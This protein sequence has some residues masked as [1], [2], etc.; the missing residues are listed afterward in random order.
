MTRGIWAGVVGRELRGVLILAFVVGALGWIQASEASAAGCINESLRAGPSEFLPDCRGYELVTPPDTNGRL[1]DG[2]STFGFEK[3]PGF[4]PTELG[5]PVRDSLLYVAYNSPLASPGESTGIFD[6][7]EAERS[8]AGW[9]TA[10]RRNPSGAQA[11]TPEPGGASPDHLYA[12]SHVR[13]IEGGARPAGSLAAEGNGEYLSNPDGSFELVGVGGE[14]TE[15]LAQGRFISANGEH[16]IFTTGRAFTQSVDCW[17]I[18]VKCP[19]HPLESNAPPAGTGAVYDRS[20]DGPTHV[21]SL[22]PGDARPETGEEAFYQGVSKDGSSVVFKINEVLYV[23]ADNGLAEER[24]EEVATGSTTFAG[25]SADGRYVFYV[26]AGDIHRFD[27]T[28][29]VDAQVNST[30]DGK[31]VNVSADGSH[32]YFIS[33]EEIEGQGAAGKPNLFVWSGG[34]PK[35]V[36][37]VAASDLVRTSGTVEGMP[38]LTNWTS[39]VVS[40]ETQSQPGPGAD[41]SRTTPDGSVIVFESRARLTSYDNGGHTEIYRYQEGDP[42]PTCISC[43]PAVEPAEGDARLQELFMMLPPVVIHNLSD[44]GGH[45]FFETPE[46]LAGRDTDGV[47]DV[48]EWKQE[49]GGSSVNLISSGKSLEYKPLLAR[50]QYLPSPNILFS[51]TPDGS[52]VFFLSQD[53]LVPGAGEEGAPAVYDARVG[54]GFP[55]AP[56]PTLCLEEECHSG[57]GSAPA[58]QGQQSEALHGS[59]NVKPGRHRHCRRAHHKKGQHGRSVKKCGKRRF[60]RVRASTAA[61]SAQPETTTAQSLQASSG[62]GPEPAAGTSEPVAHSSSFLTSSG[63]EF[64]EF[65]I[66]AVSAEGSTTAAG[67]HPDFTTVLALNSHVNVKNHQVQ[68]DAR[69]EEVSVSLPPGLLG[70]PNAIPRCSVGGLIAFGNC[71]VGS[72]VGLARL[73]ISDFGE[74]GQEAY[75]PI[76]NVAP[77]HPEKEIA[78]FG[79]FAGQYPVFLDIKVRT[80]GDYGVTATVHDGPGLASLLK[81]TTTFW[82]NPADPS[83][84]ESRLTAPEAFLGCTTACL[85]PEGKRESGIPPADRKAFMTN[86]SACQGG[87]VSFAV[88]TYQLPGQ[89]FTATAPMAPITDCKGLPFGPTFEAEPTS[90]VAGAATGLKTKLILPS[91]EGPEEP[92][93]AT[94]REARVT[95]PAGMQIAAGAANWIGTCSDAQ[96]GLHEEVD[97]ACPDAS[98]LGNAAITSPALPA[99]IEGTVYQRTPRP[100]HPFGL[101]LVVDALGLHIKLP[102]ELEPDKQTGRLTAIFADL[103]Q[104]PVEEIDLNVWGGPRAPLQNPD[105][106]GTYATDYS[107]VPHS[108]D[109]AASGQ[110]QM[111]IDEGCGQGFSPTLQAGVIEPVAGAFSPFV[112]DLVRADGQQA[113]RGFELHLPKGELAKLSGV[114]LCPDGAAA[115]GTCPAESAIGHLAASSGPGPDPLWL[116]QPGKAQPQIFLAGPYQGVPYSIVTEVP[117]Q[118]GPFDLGVVVV[119][120]ELAVDPETAQATVKADPLPQFFEGVGIAYRH[121]H[122]VIDRPNFSLNPT[123]CEELA[124][125]S[126]VASTQGAVAHPSSRFQVDGCQALKFKPKLR[127]KLK[128]GTRR[129]A[130]PA[131][132]AILEARAGD[133]N[134]ARTS[135]AL[136]HSEFLAQGHIGTICTRKQFAADECPKG[137]V[138]GKAMAITPLLDKPLEGLVYLRSSS[139][140]LPDLVIAL[141]GQVE[142]DLVGRIDSFHGGIRTTFTE[143]P[144]APVTK[145]VLKMK[146]GKKSLITNSTDICRGKHAAT[147]SISAQNGRL[148]TSKQPLHPSGCGNRKG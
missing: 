93:T 62:A 83:H 113:L 34:T 54:G 43:N 114:P 2:I 61:T 20:A 91:H 142:F 53:V 141:K 59:G 76:Y 4:F 12:F 101:W 129:A 118:A 85:A 36:A 37:T 24:T 147:V 18:G 5:S 64:E 8:E 90:H 46:A 112:F 136:P 40:P 45:V 39:K 81:A 58:L 41:S 92:A 128:G 79:F 148:L 10:R 27:T 127:L 116:P 23:R 9:Q 14:G 17:A 115:S 82:A 96:V 26:T 56:E 75:E 55:V 89:V 49:E 135:V 16:I 29:E 44:D 132:T 121:L 143:V 77:P 35:F 28:N 144:D 21:V 48:Y 123:N 11:L 146:G 74:V 57:S 78:R 105:S 95:L 122:A 19:V 22:L 60:A 134:L 124:V 133:A 130:Y 131:L 106:C 51:V 139:H 117:A 66:K 7:F 110:S 98:K 3:P 99:P 65:G 6:L 13:V 86:P 33:E 42:S 47:N 30:G 102:A 97:A 63:G 120:S 140:P 25:I 72:Q 125:T 109:L 119:R 107:F 138:Y 50:P 80:A 71:P 15:R 38:S 104:V 52:D 111:K 145:F 1:L 31:V 70:N 84:D 68:A 87:N 88:T 32:V 126:D 67:M 94:M 100:G 108:E 69:T 137:S 73:V 103:P